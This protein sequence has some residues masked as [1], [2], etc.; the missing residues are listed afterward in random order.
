MALPRTIFNPPFNI[1]RVS[2]FVLT[3]KDPVTLEAFFAHQY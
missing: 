3:A 2:H 1:A